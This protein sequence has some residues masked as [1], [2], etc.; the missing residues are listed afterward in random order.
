M[1]NKY[2]QTK[3]WEH[4]C[5]ET[6]RDP[7]KRRKR[8]EQFTLRKNDKILDLGCGD[9]LNIVVLRE[10][11]I[12]NVVGMDPSTDLL[13]AAK[14]LNPKNTFVKGVAEKLPFKKGV[15]DVVLVDSVFHHLLDY[16]VALKEIKRVLKRGG[17]LCFI[18]PHNHIVR[19]IIDWVCEQEW[20]KH[21]PF[22]AKRRV[23]YLNEINLMKHWLT[24]EQEFYASL[25]NNTFQ[26]ELYRPDF[27]SIIGIYKKA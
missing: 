25:T 22:I 21:M 12:K 16:D 5:V 7:E 23:A 11:G 2:K 3:K 8:L 20:S 18:E 9:G 14:K 24:T 13:K 26:E 19:K 17:R 15:F 6:R 4:A 10:L 1:K 27:L